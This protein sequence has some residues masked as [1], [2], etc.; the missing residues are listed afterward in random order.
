MYVFTKKKTAQCFSLGYMEFS[1]SLSQPQR[2]YIITNRCRTHVPWAKWPKRNEDTYHHV[3]SGGSSK[4][5]W[6]VTR[7]ITYSWHRNR[8]KDYVYVYLHDKRTIGK[9]LTNISYSSKCVLLDTILWQ[10]LY[11]SFHLN[12]LMSRLYFPN[13][14][15]YMGSY[16]IP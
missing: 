12:V 10:C 9:C 3:V 8:N 2:L 13:L 1:H 5:R 15:G 14:Y 7:Y 6:V 11:I 16:Y 4:F